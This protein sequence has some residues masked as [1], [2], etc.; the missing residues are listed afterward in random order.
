MNSDSSL[1]D[2]RLLLVEIR[3]SQEELVRRIEAIEKGLS[4]AVNREKLRI[5]E[6][7]LIGLV[8]CMCALTFMVF[9]AT[10]NQIAKPIPTS[11]KAVQ[12]NGK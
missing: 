8:T 2:I 5:H 12:T 4:C 10:Y 7:V 9:S 6:K 3:I 11:I 1:Q